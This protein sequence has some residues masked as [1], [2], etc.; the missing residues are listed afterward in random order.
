MKRLLAILDEISKALTVLSLILF[1]LGLIDLSYFVSIIAAAVAMIAAAII[2]RHGK[3]FAK[4]FKRFI[5]PPVLIVRTAKGEMIIDRGCKICRHQ[6]RAEIEKMLLEGR[7]YKEIAEAFGNEFSVASLS[8]HLRLH[9]PRLILEPEKLNELYQEHRIK[10]IDL[11]DE[12][13]K[14]IGRLNDLYQ[15]LE[16]LDEK[17]FGDGKPKVSP[18]AFVESISERRN[19]I[20]Q[21]RETLLTIEELKS[22]IKTEKDLSELLQKLLSK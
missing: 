9:M 16:R 20:A 8:R 3:R 15:K 2:G 4:T 12:M 18:H 11:T 14:L 1:Q 22:E 21:I 7:P 13:F 17:F 10:Q 5:R 19:I 6:R